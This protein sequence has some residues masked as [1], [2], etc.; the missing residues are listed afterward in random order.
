MRVK[1]D[2]QEGK[3]RVAIAQASPMTVANRPRNG[4]ALLLDLQRA[5]GNRHV[6]RLL[7]SG[8]IQAKLTVSEPGDQFEQ[9]ADRVA[10]QVMRM[11]E[12]EDSNRGAARS[13]NF[14]S[15]G[16]EGAEKIGRQMAEEEEEEKAVQTKEA[17]GQAPELSENMHQRISALAGRGSPL[18]ESARAFFEPR[19]DH[20]FS[21]V[22]VHTD[23]PAA[24]T[25]RGMNAMAFTVGRDIAFAAGQYS[26]DSMEGRKLLAH[27]LTHVI[28]QS[29]G[30]SRKGANHVGRLKAPLSVQ[31]RLV[32][33][34]TLA[35][36]N[37]LLGL[38]GPP[39]GLTL[40]LN[41]TTNQTRIAATAP[42]TPTSPALRT[43]LT[44]IINHATQHAEVIVGRGQPQ[45]QIGAFPQPSD[46]TV[47]RVQQ[48][49]IDDILAVEAGAA[50]NGV[51]QAAHEI[52]ENFQAHSATPVAGTDRFP[53]AHASGT[54]AESDVAEQ[55]V[56]PGRKEGS[57]SVPTSATTNTEIRDF[58]NYYLVFTTSLAAATQDR[59]IT[60]ARRATPVVISTNFINDFAPGSAA[61]PAG[62]A[63]TITAAA[64]DVAA[65]AT[66]TVLI[67]GFDD[68]GGAAAAMTTASRNR[69]ESV[70]TALAGAGVLRGRTRVEARGAPHSFTSSIRR[71][72]GSANDRFVVISVRRPGP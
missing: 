38:L 26:P 28:Q 23:S 4:A 2:R 60:S 44:N 7:S 1:T 12:P 24:E 37:A 43:Q 47:T 49:D 19:F 61:M 67:E 10:D 29:D 45:V 55:L 16:A 40:N 13:A 25:A 58:E 9:E 70:R 52:Q 3:Q 5:Q 50:G 39:A 63:A 35:D 33:F 36:V 41:V 42:G 62:S 6:Q 31:R 64:A 21:D 32:T 65:N 51:A 18:P 20:D 53:A 68:A 66:S 15:M 14:S 57:V 17:T 69:G 54:T 46:L 22:R 11:A 27:E 30:A 56:G 8:L 48:I 59:T 34:G 72:L 71:F